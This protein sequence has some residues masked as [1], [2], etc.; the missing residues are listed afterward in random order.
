MIRVHTVEDEIRDRLREALPDASETILAQAQARA[1][2][3]EPVI[4]EERAIANAI[5][6]ARCAVHPQ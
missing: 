6:W 1:I 3:S 4:G 2:R 5:A